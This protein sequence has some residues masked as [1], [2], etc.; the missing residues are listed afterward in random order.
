MQTFQFNLLA[1]CPVN[2]PMVALTE[3]KERFAP[4]IHALSDSEAQ[5]QKAEEHCVSN[6]LAMEEGC[7]VDA[8]LQEL[9]RVNVENERLNRLAMTEL[10]QHAETIND[11]N[12]ECG[13]LLSQCKKLQEQVDQVTR[14]RDQWKEVASI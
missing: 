6:N 9:A 11:G 2:G 4:I 14:E 10:Q 12:V 13:L 3:V 7:V 5:L 8:L 1:H